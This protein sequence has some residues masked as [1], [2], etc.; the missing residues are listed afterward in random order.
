MVIG[1]LTVTV[2]VPESASLKDKR[3]VIRP[4]TSRVRHT[5]NVAIAEVGER[6]LWQSATLGIACVSESSRHADEVCQKVLGFLEQNA[7]GQIT[8][9]RFELV[10]L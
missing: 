3:Q 7:G 6:D 9:S 5:F 4:L 8:S 1:T 10:H 2:L